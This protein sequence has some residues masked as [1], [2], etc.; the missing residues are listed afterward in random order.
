V[1][2]NIESKDSFRIES[3]V[4]TSQWNRVNRIFES[5]RVHGI[6]GIEFSSPLSRLESNRESYESNESAWTRPSLLLTHMHRTRYHIQS[7]NQK[8][9]QKSKYAHPVGA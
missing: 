3:R 2:R 5:K 1:N 9:L 8:M 4:Q 7:Q 6:E